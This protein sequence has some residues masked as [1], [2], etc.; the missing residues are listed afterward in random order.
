MCKTGWVVVVEQIDLNQVLTYIVVLALACFGG[1]VDF[2]NEKKKKRERQ[3]MRFIFFS[4]F[5]RLLS[6][7]FAGLFMLWILQAKAENGVVILSGWS[8]FS[9][10]I[11][12]YLGDQA[13][14]LFV[15]IW[16]AIYNRGGK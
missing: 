1:L 9:I 12:G 11:S 16:D 14:K 5:A 10:A 4:L 13:I 7:G 8:A 3:S 2:V 6:A 15:A